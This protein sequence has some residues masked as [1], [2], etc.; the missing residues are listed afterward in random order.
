[1]KHKLSSEN[2]GLSCPQGRREHT[3]HQPSGRDMDN[4]FTTSLEGLEKT[5]YYLK[6]D[7]FCMEL[8]KIYIRTVWADMNKKNSGKTYR[9]IEFLQEQQHMQ[10]METSKSK[11]DFSEA[12][13]L[14]NHI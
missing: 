4:Q 5:R 9:D 10:E 2:L 13:R 7:Q 12:R 3:V 1:M 8:D 11:Q 14:V 6:A